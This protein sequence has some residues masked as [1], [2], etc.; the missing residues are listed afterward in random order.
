MK[1]SEFVRRVGL[2]YTVISVNYGHAIKVVDAFHDEV[3]VI[4]C[5]K[6]S[7]IFLFTKD[8][9]LAKLCLEYAETPIE[10]REEEKK[11]TVIVPDPE[12]R[13]KHVLALGRLVERKGEVIIMRVKKETL[14]SDRCQLTESEIKRNHEY[15]WQFAKEVAE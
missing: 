11:Y 3:A 14:N 5:F 6:S 8:I 1:T 4:S 12:K 13:G 7:D 2:R 10:E 15:L 9:E